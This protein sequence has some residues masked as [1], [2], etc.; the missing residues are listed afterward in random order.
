MKEKIIAFQGRSRTITS[1][2]TN[3]DI[4]TDVVAAYQKIGEAGLKLY[5]KW[6]DLMKN[7]E[8][9]KK[10]SPIEQQAL[11]EN[12]RS[13]Q[14]TLTNLDQEIRFL[15]STKHPLALQDANAFITAANILFDKSVNLLGGMDG[16]FRFSSLKHVKE[17][18]W[19]KIKYL[20]KVFNLATELDLLILDFEEFLNTE[21]IELATQA[22][23]L[24]ELYT[25]LIQSHAWLGS[26]YDR[27]EKEG[28]PQVREFKLPEIQVPKIPEDGE[29]Q[30]EATMEIVKDSK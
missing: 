26:E 28:M 2:L 13:Y 10:L 16:R 11:H 27:I 19:D 30:P 23:I 6:R 20:D 12:M 3:L 8:E 4:N 18:G 1:F 22:C 9:F 21:P 5:S 25:S 14:E 24:A 15:V 17:K 29:K 7:E